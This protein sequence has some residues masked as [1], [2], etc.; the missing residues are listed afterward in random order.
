LRRDEIDFIEQAL[1]HL[2]GT[3]GP[4]EARR[5]DEGLASD[6]E[7]ARRY[8]ALAVQRL[9]LADLGR[10]RAGA[11]APRRRRAWIAARAGAL[12]LGA[13]AALLVARGGREPPRREP[14]IALPTAGR[15]PAV[16][17]GRART[18]AAPAAAPIARTTIEAVA[19]AVAVV[20][21]GATAPARPGRALAAGEG[22]A[23]A[24]DGGH[25]TVRVAGARLD[26]GAGST[27]GPLG[28]LRA[29]AA[30][31]APGLV[32]PVTQG[33]VH[34]DFGPQAPAPLALV[35]ALGEARLEAP[36]RA[37][38]DVD[39]GQTRV[40]V[41]EG[42]AALSSYADGRKLEL[43]A[44]A[45]ATLAI[46]RAPLIERL[47]PP[48]PVAFTLQASPREVPV[49]RRIP[50]SLLSQ[51]RGWAI[52]KNGLVVGGNEEGFTCA[53]SQRSGLGRVVVGAVMESRALVDEGWGVIDTTMR[54]QAADG[55][56][57]D[58]PVCDADWLADLA[59]ALVVL[60]ESGLERPYR[61][62]IKALLPRLALTAHYLAQP[63]V[64]DQVTGTDGRTSRR[65][66]SQ[67]V[68]FTFA[69][70]LLGDPGLAALGAEYLERALQLQRKDGS[71]VI[72]DGFDSI[73]QAVNLEH[74]S[75]LAL[76]L[77]RAE[78][79]ARLGAEWL[80]GRIT[81]AG[82][83]D[84]RGN[85]ATFGARCARDCV[86]P[87]WMRLGWALAYH[88]A[89]ADPALFERALRMLG[90]HRTIKD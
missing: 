28:A 43:G 90:R 36:A 62:Q 51:L 41:F 76:R 17:G 63:A 88:A 87:D 25:A 21:E 72:N 29:E 11:F 27:V 3:L 55:S 42:A 53:G 58:R 1:K 69:G 89:A 32:L 65:L 18:T 48:A 34:V 52:R 70:V 57:L 33:R 7:R 61:R 31:A 22:L 64:R 60:L 54:F 12:A 23:V 4:E 40:E 84:L 9:Q 73:L 47:E 6:P 59:H 46:D 2:D 24:G 44:G 19:G 26:L 86:G 37:R 67:S 68:G 78:A 85:T 15:P 74:L 16:A 13:I 20:A 75:W 10:T 83:W 66:L 5:F 30:G 79:A 82:E 39:S 56:F 38:V 14:A 35:T 50:A 49:L 77:P 45:L 80:L 81:P 71:F 8:C